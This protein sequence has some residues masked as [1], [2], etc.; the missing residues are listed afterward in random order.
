[1]SDTATPGGRLDA[2]IEKA[3]TAVQELR[4]ALSAKAAEV[5]QEINAKVDEIQA[6]IDEIQASRGD[7][8]TPPEATQL[9]A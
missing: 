6:A 8:E 2:A 1:M 3:H 5:G 9:P 4:Q 7:N